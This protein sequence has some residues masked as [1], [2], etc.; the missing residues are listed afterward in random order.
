YVQWNTRKCRRQQSLVQQEAGE[1]DQGLIQIH[2]D[3]MKHQWE[4]FDEIQSNIE[5][6]DP[7]EESRSYEI[8]A[9]YYAIVNRA[10]QLIQTK[11]SISQT[12][13]VPMAVKLP[14]MSLPTF[15]GASESWFSFFDI[16]SS[17][18]DQ[19]KALTPVQKLQYLRSTL[20]GRAAS[21]IKALST[22]D[23][24]YAEA[25]ELLKGKFDNTRK[26]IMQH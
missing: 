19:N 10:N 9:N 12:V 26:N 21:C 18:I 6:L 5:E 1:Y 15:D 25:I 8:Q 17:V 2:L 4:T 16:F 22:T 20:R 3:G 14:E 24:N 23:A 7:S 13:I 11:P